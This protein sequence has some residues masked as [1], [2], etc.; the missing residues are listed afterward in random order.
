MRAIY[1]W[2]LPDHLLLPPSFTLGHFDVAFGM[3]RVTTLIGE[4]PGS[5]PISQDARVSR[6]VTDKPGAFHY[7]LR[8]RGHGVYV[9]SIDGTLNCDGT[10]LKRGDSKGIWNSDEIICETG[11]GDTDVLLVETVM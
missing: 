1:F 6:L 11:R 4:E 9:F 8:S 2:L 3:N 5:V 10:T 7:R